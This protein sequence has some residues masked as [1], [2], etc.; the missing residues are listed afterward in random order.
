MEFQEKREDR[1]I[2][3]VF[4]FMLGMQEYFLLMNKLEENFYGLKVMV[5]ILYKRMVCY[6]L[7]GINWKVC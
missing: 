3:Q 6:D 1:V 2:I 5:F 4:I 7:Y